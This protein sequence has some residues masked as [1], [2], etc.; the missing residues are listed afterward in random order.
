MA[1]R[2]V[3]LYGELSSPTG[4]VTAII[5]FNNQQV[6]S[7]AINT[8]DAELPS[9]PESTT[10]IATFDV[11]EEI[12]GSVP[13]SVSVTGGAIMAQR[14]EATHMVALS[15]AVT[16]TSEEYTSFQQYSIGGW[17]DKDTVRV[18]GV[19]MGT[20]NSHTGSWPIAVL[21]GQVMECNYSIASIASL[22]ATAPA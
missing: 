3:K 7:G 9:S 14:M 22:P 8:S 15:D 4:S 21:D 1:N 19:P 11:D 5:N 20:D 13:F 16:E 17:S 10:V 2:T 18:D 12:V 6:F